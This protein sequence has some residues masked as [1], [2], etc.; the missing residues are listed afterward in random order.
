MHIH[1]FDLTTEDFRSVE[2]IINR[3]ER[4][5]G[6]LGRERAGLIMDITACHNGACKLDLAAM[7]AGRDADL[8]HDVAG[9]YRHFNRETGELEGCFTPRHAARNAEV[10][11]G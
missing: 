7:A 10:H 9:I 5:A 8:A 1:N 6:P 2:T 11:H 3:F 4:I